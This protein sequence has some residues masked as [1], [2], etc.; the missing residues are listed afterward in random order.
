MLTVPELLVEYDRALAYTESLWRD[1]SPDEVRWRPND[2]SSA[3]GWHLGHQA[4]VAHFMI[5][6]LTAAEP[7]PDAD[8][9]PLMDSSS[10]VQAR[11]ELPDL[12][13]LA[14]FRA[15]VADRV[16]VRIGDIAARNV[17]APVQM[18]VVASALL[19]AVINHEYQHSQWIG[20]VRHRDLGHALPDRP[21]SD[22]L[23]EL[24]GYLVVGAAS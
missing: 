12:G 3:I 2:D 13:R 10:N 4:T 14:D 6:N 17:G 23:C 20:E 7:S 21:V 24:D 15:K 19:T 8:L 22:V 11:G 5:R 18:Q 1:L 9:E 16:H